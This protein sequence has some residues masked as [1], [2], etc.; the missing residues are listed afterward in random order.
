M[1][2]YLYEL[3]NNHK[4]IIK[5][6]YEAQEKAKSYILECPWISR[7]SKNNINIVIPGYHK[8]VFLLEDNPKYA[9]ELFTQALNEDIM[10]KTNK[11]K[12]LECDIERLQSGISE[13]QN[14][15]IIIEEEEEIEK[16]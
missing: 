2:I 1:K 3:K 9:K 11:I 8:K 6:E 7:L 13:L 15:A 4:E 5:E 16:E 12:A 14:A 10:N